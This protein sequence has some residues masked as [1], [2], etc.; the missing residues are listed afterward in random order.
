[1]SDSREQILR[2]VREARPAAVAAPDVAEAARAFTRPTIDPTARFAEVARA[3]GAT[4]EQTTRAELLASLAALS[5]GSARRLSYVD[6]IAG[7]IEPPADP[8]ALH[9]LDLLIA[10]GALGVAES[11]AVWLAPRDAIQRAALFLAERV[12]LVL[13]GAAIVYD[14]HQAYGR[15]EVASADFGVFVAGPSK[16]ADIE[17]SL[18]IGAHGPKSLSVI[19]VD[20]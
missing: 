20:G 6:G 13:D 7:T 10:R 15:L 11:G 14:L 5:V 17:Q 3:A 8:H 16:T 18:V 19:V 4:V 1:M 2:A 9:D 12:V